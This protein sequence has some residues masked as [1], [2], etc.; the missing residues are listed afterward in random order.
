MALFLIEPTFKY[1]KESN[2]SPFP[3]PLFLLVRVIRFAVLQPWFGGKCKF[4]ER[5]LFVLM[6]S[7]GSWHS[8]RLFFS[9]SH[10]SRESMMLSASTLAP[11]VLKV[12]LLKLNKLIFFQQLWELL[13]NVKSF[14]IFRV[15]SQFLTAT[16]LENASLLIV[17]FVI[18]LEM[19]SFAPKLLTMTFRR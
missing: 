1:E 5:R 3:L 17:G 18:G 4:F 8:L 15:E 11:N 10:K 2:G 13:I 9:T 7:I 19:I 6:T 14:C 12:A 16:N